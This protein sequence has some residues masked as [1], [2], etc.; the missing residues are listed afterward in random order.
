MLVLR[1]LAIVAAP[2]GAAAV[3][4]YNT[5]SGKAPI[6]T[7]AAYAAVAT[8]AAYDQTVLNSP[9][10]PSPA[11]TT[12]FLVQL[13]PG[14][15][16]GLSI[17]QKGSFMG[18]SV[19]LSVAQ[20]TLGKNSTYLQVPFLNYLSNVRA[21]GGSVSV[22]VG[23][24]SQDQAFLVPASDIPKGGVIGKTAQSGAT[25]PTETPDVVFSSD[26][27]TMMKAIG[28]LVN[29]DFYFGLN[30]FNPD[31][32]TNAVLVAQTAEQILGDR[33][34]GF[35]LGNEPD[36]YGSHGRR[37]SSYSMQNYMNDYQT[38]I[39]DLNGASLSNNQILIGP[40]TC[41][42]WN[43]T[44]LFNLGYLTNYAANLKMVAVQKYPTDNCK[45]N[46]NVHDP[47]ETFS[48]FTTHTAV[49]NL[50]AGYTTSSAMVQAAGKPFVLM[51][52][53]TAS[54]GGFPGISDSFAATMW[55]ADL[56]FQFAFINFSQVMLHVGGQDT[57]YNPFTPPPTNLSTSFGWTTGAV[58]YSTLLVAEA[59]GQSGDAQIV[60]LY[61]NGNN[62][63]TP[64]YAIYE[65]GNPARVVLFN[66]I[67]DATGA[68]DY[69]AN[70]AIGGQQTGVASTT[71]T[72]VSV[73]YMRAPSLGSHNV[74][75]A[76][77]TMGGELGSDGRLNGTVETVTIQCDT[78]AQTCA[79]P[80]KAPSIALVFL[81]DTAL[82][83]SSPQASVTQ[84]FPTSIVTQKNPSKI[85]VS[86]DPTVLATSNGRGAAE[87]DLLGS[88]S[89]GSQSS[90]ALG[91]LQ[92]GA[93]ALAATTIGISLS[94]FLVSFTG[95][96]LR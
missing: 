68:N 65:N 9:S 76:G 15:M 16:D 85:T 5:K 23:G 71:P 53:N 19:E 78:T 64:G 47:Q 31:N 48:S 39:N 35:Q 6:A 70:V 79:I 38:M 34:L 94:L 81:T 2:L 49:T 86:V 18:F 7:S 25:T 44:D 61:M 59:F 51:E 55:A 56:G 95:L 41:C 93:A 32:E 91:R 40:S 88:T 84:T 13:Y 57:Y 36:L 82:Q 69:T 46:G 42:N 83:A 74:T 62:P 29:A 11:I 52:T 33:L 14:S 12:S 58:Y 54:C 92:T 45:I 60:D 8:L 3:T 75:W 37:N 28:D 1:L 87:H 30:F 22:R 27:L 73:R 10:P 21:R 90:D 89:E 72:S 43:E 96:A 24:N 50:A 67:D 66:Y 17:K 20:V 4:V 77:Q 26:L 80:V 63:L